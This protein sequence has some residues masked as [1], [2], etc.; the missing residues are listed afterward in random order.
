[1]F[2]YEQGGSRLSEFRKIPGEFFGKST[3]FS[4]TFCKKYENQW[5]KFEPQILM[6]I[7]K[8]GFKNPCVNI[9]IQYG[10][11]DPLHI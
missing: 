9:V 8:N 3:T 11:L 1:M 7:P 4:V 10:P 5:Q 2:T 6:S